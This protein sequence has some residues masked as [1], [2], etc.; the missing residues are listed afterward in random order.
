M[1]LKN[2]DLLFCK[3]ELI[4]Y[5]SSIA[6]FWHHN[7]IVM[8]KHLFPHRRIGPKGHRQIVIF[9]T[10]LGKLITPLQQ[11]MKYHLESSFVTLPVL[12]AVLRLNY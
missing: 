8:Q 7:L 11:L 5:Q 1:I 2:T 3:K 4:V 6:P 9:K 12:I 10:L